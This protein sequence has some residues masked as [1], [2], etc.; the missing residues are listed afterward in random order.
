[1]TLLFTFI[2]S[3]VLVAFSIPSIIKIAHE[4][5]LFDAPHEK[6]KIHKSITP[7][8]GGLGIFTGFLIALA[9]FVKP[10]TLKEC[11]YLLAGGV[12][13]FIIGIK[14]DIIGVDP[15]KK[16]L[17]Q[18]LA[19]FVIV[20]LGDVRIMDLGGFLEIHHLSYPFSI[21]LSVFLIVGVTNAYN[22]I[23]G[24][25]GLAG[26]LGV[27]GSLLYAYL[28]YSCNELGWVY[29]C[30]SLAGS[31]IG[32]LIYNFSPAK[33]FMGDSGSLMLG[34]LS[35]VL[36]IKFL[37][38]ATANQ[39]YV[40]SLFISAPIAIP[41]AVTIVPVFDTLRIFTIRIMRNESPFKADR[42]HIHHRL[43]FVGMNHTKATLTL[44]T[45]TLIAM[46][47]AIFCQGIGNNQLVATIE[48]AVI[49]LNLAL[50]IYTFSIKKYL[51]NEEETVITVEE[52][53]LDNVKPLKLNHHISTTE[54]EYM[55][56]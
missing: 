51:P 8:L 49:S 26:S 28:F 4:K 55:N 15:L 50:S 27:V 33:I 41:F 18:F 38:I 6:R 25:D 11:N 44:V 32:F 43:L 31:L 47:I 42:N 52:D 48:I 9:L 54:K 40:N 30:L 34:F 29:I 12:I 2:T 13:I 3:L 45:T 46:L 24:I 20:I 1:M 35:A 5:N 22:L 17:A 19:A 37:N 23:D 16:F 14:D 21:G 53:I 10:E 56:L 36:S 7:N 39:V